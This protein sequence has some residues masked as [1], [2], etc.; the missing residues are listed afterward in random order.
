MKSTERH[1]LKENEFA[2][3]VARAREVLDRR[4]RDVTTVLVAIIAVLA[5]TVGYT[6]WRQS[7]TARANTML[8]AALAVA[9]APVVPLPAPAPGSPIPVQQ[10]GTFLTEQARL[11][12]A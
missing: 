11:E 4:G 7:R 3:K 1:K 8:A 5:L 2:I 6:T 12:A 9:E 10:P